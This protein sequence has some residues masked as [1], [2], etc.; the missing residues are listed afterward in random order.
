MWR[1]LQEPSSLSLEARSGPCLHSPIVQFGSED[2]LLRIYTD[3][4]MVFTADRM[5]RH[6]SKLLGTRQH[7]KLEV[8]LVNETTATMTVNRAAPHWAATLHE[9][10][11]KAGYGAVQV[12]LQD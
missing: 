5:Q 3:L 7:G 1:V 11:F 2:Q 9:M 10:C 4:G 8:E 12:E 6:I